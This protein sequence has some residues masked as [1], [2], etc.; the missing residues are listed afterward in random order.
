M[1]VFTEKGKSKELNFVDIVLLI[2]TS[3]P[4]DRSIF[5]TI[6]SV[7]RLDVL[8]FIVIYGVWTYFEVLAILSSQTSDSKAGRTS[9][10]VGVALVALHVG[11]CMV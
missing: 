11:H 8:P 5:R 7:Q 1:S 10:I 6:R 9:T 2:Q 4:A 3:S